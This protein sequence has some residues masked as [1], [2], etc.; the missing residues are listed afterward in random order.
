MLSKQD[1]NGSRNLYNSL[2]SFDKSDIYEQCLEIISSRNTE[3]LE[4][5][6]FLFMSLRSRDPNIIRIRK[7]IIWYLMSFSGI[8]TE[9]TN[10]EYKFIRLLIYVLFNKPRYYNL[11]VI[12]LLSKTIRCC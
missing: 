2:K 4:A 9:L 1:D 8:N 12:N 11:N 7:A 3:N 5:I 6:E 10:Q